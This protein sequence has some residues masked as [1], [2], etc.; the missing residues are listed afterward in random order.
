M[1]IA[2][3][4]PSGLGRGLSAL[5]GEI[6]APRTVPAAEAAPLEVKSLSQP[7]AQ[8]AEPEV[9]LAKLGIGS[10]SRT[11]PIHKLH[12]NPDQPRRRFEPQA[13]KDLEESIR[14]HGIMQPI[15]V[16]P[17]FGPRGG[18]FEIVA[19]ERRW[20][21]AMNVPLHEVPIIIRLLDDAQVLELALVENIQRQDLNPIEEAV[22]YKRLMD[23]FGHTQEALGTL[24]GKSRAH[25]ANL[26]R[27]LELPETVR[28][29]VIEGKISMGHARAVI[30]AL[31]PVGL[32]QRIIK[33]D[34]SV[35]E[36]ERLAK[37]ARQP[38]RPGTKPK[39]GQASA[40]KDADTAAL[41]RDLSS[42][43]GMPVTIDFTGQKGRV[44]IEYG[45]LDQLDDLCQRLCAPPNVRSGF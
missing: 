38:D 10:A 5:L 17:L 34:L 2:P 30:T 27:L 21:A 4:K 3:K 7:T 16:R 13:L 36:T 9:D 44:I 15:M 1:T 29:F 35:R 45:T 20:R 14:A 8:N 32:A 12:P 22:G 41:E 42:A 28:G 24:V 31:D 6:A 39:S 23:E 25:V 18:E 19:G 26:L 40:T 11:V 33:D 43:V 37:A